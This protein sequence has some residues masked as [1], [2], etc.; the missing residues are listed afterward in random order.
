MFSVTDVPPVRDVDSRGGCARVETASV[1]K[2]LH[3]RIVCHEP[4]PARRQ[5]VF[6]N[7]HAQHTPTRASTTERVS[8]K[9]ENL[10]NLALYLT[11]KQHEVFLL[12]NNGTCFEW[13][14]ELQRTD[15]FRLTRNYRISHKT[16]I[17]NRLHNKHFQFLR[18]EPLTTA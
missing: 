13:G 15:H 2:P 14:E 7:D 9:C 10:R 1:W 5:S 11:S 8:D 17:S 16:E 4:K 18:L 12:K 6:K 3:R